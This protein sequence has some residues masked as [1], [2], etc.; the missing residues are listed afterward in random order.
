MTM[1]VSAS[2][3]ILDQNQELTTLNNL[4]KVVVHE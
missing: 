3:Y 2:G 4:I 1:A